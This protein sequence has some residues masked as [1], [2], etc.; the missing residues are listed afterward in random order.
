MPLAVREIDCVVA[1]KPFG[2]VQEYVAPATAAV[3]RLIVSASQYVVVPVTT[4]V[5]GVGF[6]VTFA[7]PAADVQPAT[8]IVT[9]YAPALPLAGRVID[10]VFAVK[11]FGPVQAY[12]VPATAAV[13]RLIVSA[14]QYVVVPVTTGVAGVGFTV[15]FAVPAADVQPATV[16]VTE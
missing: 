1:V 12:V 8:V 15:T 7:V 9:E 2:P 6:T 16:I 11:P 5:A 3:D 10:C 4:G 14:S 13:E